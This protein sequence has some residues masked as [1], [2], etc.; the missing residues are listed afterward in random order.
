MDE[1]ISL[2]N[3]SDMYGESSSHL[4]QHLAPRVW[5]E[6]REVRML[7]PQHVKDS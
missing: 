1:A 3:P 4:A 5:D 6:T 2:W 7:P